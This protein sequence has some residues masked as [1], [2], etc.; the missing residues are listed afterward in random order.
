MSD[1]ASDAFLGLL[2]DPALLYLGPI[3]LAVLSRKPPV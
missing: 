1:P 3:L 2:D